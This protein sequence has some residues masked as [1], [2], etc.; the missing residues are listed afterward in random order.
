MGKNPIRQSCNV[1]QY[2]QMWW[3]A[4]CGQKHKAVFHFLP[5]WNSSPF[6]LVRLHRCSWGSRCLPQSSR[7]PPW[8]WFYWSVWQTPSIRLTWDH[9]LLPVEHYERCPLEPG[10]RIRLVIISPFY[11]YSPIF[12][13]YVS[14]LKALSSGAQRCHKCALSTKQVL[15]N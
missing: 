10:I 6:Q 14:A 5:C 11:R 12:E 4:E 1:N 9:S 3:N 2:T 15:I 7:N 8:P 13:K